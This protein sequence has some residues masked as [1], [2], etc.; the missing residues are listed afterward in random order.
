MEVHAD[1]HL[2]L[3]AKCLSIRV[4]LQ[5]GLNDSCTLVLVVVAVIVVVVVL[6]VVVVV[7]VVSTTLFTLP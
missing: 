7:V 3:R 1:P 4:A 6:R 5:S 2:E